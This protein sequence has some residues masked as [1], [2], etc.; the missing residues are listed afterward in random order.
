MVGL[1]SKRM[2]ILMREVFAMRCR[3]MGFSQG[4]G[5]SMAT[6]HGLVTMD[7]TKCLRPSA[8]FAIFNGDPTKFS[9][10]VARSRVGGTPEPSMAIAACEL[11]CA[12]CWRPDINEVQRQGSIAC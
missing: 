4:Y 2:K 10:P 7:T 8:A 11:S 12:Y 9:I 5:R 1:F 6:Q 3:L